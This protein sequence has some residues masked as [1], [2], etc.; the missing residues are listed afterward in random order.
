VRKLWTGRPKFFIN[1]FCDKVYSFIPSPPARPIVPKPNTFYYALIFGVVL[2]KPFA[3]ALKL[4]PTPVFV[5]AEFAKK[6][7]D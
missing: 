5:R 6:F 3:D 4:T 1:S 2:K 7:K